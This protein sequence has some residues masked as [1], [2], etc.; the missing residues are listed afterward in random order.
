[1]TS[2]TS[3]RSSRRPDLRAGCHARIGLRRGR[4]A[5]APRIR[6]LLDRRRGLDGRLVLQRTRPAGRCRRHVAGF[7]HRGRDPQRGPVVAISPVRP[8][9]RSDRRP[10]PPPAAARRC[11]SRPGARAGRDPAGSNAG[12]PQPPAADRRRPRLRHVVTRVRRRTPV[13]PA[14]ARACGAAHTGVRATGADECGRTDRRTGARGCTDQTDRGTGRDPGRCGVVPALRHRARHRP[15][16]D[17]G[18]CQR[19]RSAAEPAPRRSTKGS[20]GSTATA[21]SDRSR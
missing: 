8:D 10:V 13:V 1:M 12:R 17:T 19:H 2:P 21:L 14:I 15:A 11:R 18:S 5:G 20:A 7:R 9:R 3:G 4:P 16:T 6:P